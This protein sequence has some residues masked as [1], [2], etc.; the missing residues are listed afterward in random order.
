MF[1][2]GLICVAGINSILLFNIIY[3]HLIYLPD[4]KDIGERVNFSEAVHVGKVQKKQALSQKIV[5][6]THCTG[7]IL[8]RLFKNCAFFF[9]HQYFHALKNIGLK[10]NTLSMYLL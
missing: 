3:V 1:H 4:R 6:F 9:K 7:E 5:F 2:P 10:H 8:E